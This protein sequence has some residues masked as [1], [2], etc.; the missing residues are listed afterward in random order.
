MKPR[1]SPALLLNTMI[2]GTFLY[3][4]G[5][6]TTGN[7]QSADT[8][9][10]MK[11]VEEDYI[12]AS[13]QVD[14]TGE[15]LEA[16]FDPDQPDEK[17]AFENYSLNVDKMKNQE[18]RLS[19]QA[20]KMRVQQRDYFEEWRMQGN[21]YTNPDIQALSEQRRA[22]LTEVFA[23]ITEASVGVKGSFKSYM[24]DNEQIRAYLS[25][26]LTPKGIEAITPVGQKA[27]TDG[28]NLKEAVNPVLAA[29]GDAREAM[30]Q[31]EDK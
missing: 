25:T 13:A 14:I 29:I 19:R 17:K 11:Q 5:C 10:T 2:L 12:Q 23:R 3:Q 22:D 31:G 26:D 30:A 18:N 20:D 6:A 27:V 24:S 8:R 21:A 4:A 9:V 16:I 1:I 15:S 28:D 7:Q